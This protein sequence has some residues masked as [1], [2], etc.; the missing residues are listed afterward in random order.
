MRLDSSTA[1]IVLF[2]QALG[3]RVNH[4]IEAELG[5]DQARIA[6]TGNRHAIVTRKD[7]GLHA[8]CLSDNYFHK[9]IQ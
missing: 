2:L 4:P 3:Y 6:L 7:S 8:K 5:D 1:E 9:E